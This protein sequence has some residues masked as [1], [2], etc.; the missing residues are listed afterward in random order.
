MAVGEGV[1]GFCVVDSEEFC[2][3]AEVAA[4][5]LRDYF[6]SLEVAPDVHRVF[7]FVVKL[8]LGTALVE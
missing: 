7:G 1:V 8:W 3:C 5:V 2:D 4:E 6:F